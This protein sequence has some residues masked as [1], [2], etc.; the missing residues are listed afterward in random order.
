MTDVTV[1]YLGPS[2]SVNVEPYGPHRKDEEK[3]YPV[4]FA[5]ELLE[6]SK[7]QKFEAV[8]GPIPKKDGEPKAPEAM[9]VAELKDELEGEEIPSNALKADLAMMVVKKREKA[10][11][12]E[13]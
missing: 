2:E 4:E 12:G 6:T 13:E 5:R 11:G 8:G 7:K 10:A 9:T 1:K 3:E